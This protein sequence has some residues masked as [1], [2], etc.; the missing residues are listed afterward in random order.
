M[1]CKADIRTPPGILLLLPGSILPAAPKR[2]GQIGHGGLHI[3]PHGMRDRRTAIPG[4][5]TQDQA[6][7]TG[8]AFVPLMR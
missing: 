8:L 2:K 3:L 1:D 7:E 5:S 4:V 6:A